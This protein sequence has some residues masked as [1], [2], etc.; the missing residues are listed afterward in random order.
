M[1]T[2]LCIVASVL[3]SGPAPAWLHQVCSCVAP[4]DARQALSEA[5]AVIEG[6]A[7]FQRPL[8][9]SRAY[10]VV[11]GLSTVA[12]ILV[13]KVWKGEIGDTLYA[14]SGSGGTDC[15]FLLTQGT[16]YILFLDR[17]PDGRWA[18][19]TCS[20]STAI[21]LAPGLADSLGPPKARAQ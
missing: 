14:F 7:G 13:G 15:G 5:T 3:A 12:R 9:A 2:T 20:R 11:G 10:P 6:V 8:G 18:V 19:S 1:I 16:R 4:T 21:A 17:V